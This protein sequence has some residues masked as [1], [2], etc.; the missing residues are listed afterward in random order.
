[1]TMF[2]KHF[3]ALALLFATLS[4]S[5]QTQIRVPLER[6]VRVVQSSGFPESVALGE[7]FDREAKAAYVFLVFRSPLTQ[8]ERFQLE[9]MGILLGP[10]LPPSV[11][12][13]E[14]PIDAAASLSRFSKYFSWLPLGDDRISKVLSQGIPEWSRV[15]NGRA[16]FNAMLLPGDQISTQ[17]V[18][19][20]GLGYSLRSIRRESDR[21][22]IEIEGPDQF[23]N[24][25]NLPFV[26]YLQESEEPGQPENFNAR[27][28]HRILS[29]QPRIES[30]YN[31]AG[32]VIGHGDDGAI[33]PHID[34]QGRMLADKS[35]ASS[36]THGDHVAGTILGG[37]NLD[38]RG[39]GM[40]PGADLVYYTYPDNLNDVD[41]DFSQYG[42]RI[43][44]SSY[45]NG[46][47][48]GYT[49]FSAQVDADINAN[50]GLQ[51]VF[52]A[53]NN[54]T[55]NCGYG[56][57]NLWG[58]ITGG[59]K[60]GKN[61]ITVANLNST[62][63]INSSS[64]RGPTAD[65]RIKP[66]VAAVGTNVY[67][68]VPPND[69]DSFTGTSMA[70][71]GT[72]GTTAV[73]Y[74]AYRETHSGND[75]AS[76]LLKG[77]LLNGADDLGNLG[78]D[79]IHGYGRINARAALED[80][81][82]NHFFTQSVDQSE[83][84]TFVLNV[85]AGTSKVKA[86]LI[87]TE[88]A[89]SPAALRDLVNNLD[90][91][92]SAAGSVYLPWVLDPS[93]NAVTLA[94]PAVQGVDSLNNIEQIT[95]DNPPALLS[96]SVSGS[97]VLQGPQE[98]Y[99]VY[100]FEGSEPLWESPAPSQALVPGQSEILRWWSPANATANIALDYSLDQGNTWVSIAQNLPS[101]ARWFNWNPP[102]S[103]TG[104]CRVRLTQGGF[105]TQT[106]D[107]SCLSVPSGLFVAQACPD[108]VELSWYGVLGATA[109]DVFALGQR[110]MDS[111]GT[112][113]STQGLN[114]I[115]I[116]GIAG[117]DE[118]WFAVRS[119]NAQ[120]P[121]QRSRAIFKP[122]G[123]LQCT[124]SRDLEA[125]SIL[126]PAPGLIPDCM[127]DSLNAGLIIKNS[128]SLS[129]H[130]Y[131][132]RFRLS[133]SL[134]FDS[135]LSSSD[136]LLPG[137]TDTVFI[138]LGFAL[139]AGSYLA[140]A[141]VLLSLDG[142]PS[143]DSLAHN[144][145]VSASSV[146]SGAFVSDFEN[147]TN[148]PSTTDCELTVCALD[149]FWTNTTNGSLDDIDWRTDNGGTP[150][151]GTGPS[152]DQ[153]PGTQAGKYLYLEASNGCSFQT[154]VL[155]SACLDLSAMTSPELSFWYHQ[156]GANQGELH[157]DLLSNG[158]WI[159]DALAPVLGNQGNVW[160]QAL[161]DLRPYMGSSLSIRIRGVTGS[162]FAS[163]LAIDHVSV[164]E[165]SS[166]PV[167]QFSASASAGC[168]GVPIQ[169]FE[170]CTHNP[171]QFQWVFSPATVAYVQGTSAQSANPVVVF[172][173]GG[174]YSAKL[175]AS[176]SLGSDSLAISQ[177]V[178][179]DG[180]RDLPQAES[181]SALNFPPA[182]YKQS[183]P[184]GSNTWVASNATGPNG[185]SSRCTRMSF[186]GYADFGQVD[187]LIS[188][189][190][191]VPNQ[192]SPALVFRRAHAQSM[193]GMSYDGL[194]IE[195]SRNCGLDFDASIFEKFGSDLATAAFSSQA[196]Q[197]QSS[198]WV[199]DTLDLS[200]FAGEELIFSFTAINGNGNHLYLDQIQWVDISQPAIG[201]AIILSDN[202]VCRGDTLQATAVP[203]APGAVSYSWRPGPGLIMPNTA[204]QGP[205][206]VIAQSVSNPV[207]GLEM[208]SEG[209]LVE[210]SAPIA[211]RGDVSAVFGS[212]L[213]ANL[214]EYA[215][216]ENFQGQPTDW[217]W[218]FGDGNS[219]L[220]AVQ[221][222]HAYANPGAYTVRLSAWNECGSDTAEVSIAV[223]GIGLDESNSSGV[224][225]YP[226]PLKN[227]LQA[228]NIEPAT[229]WTSLRLFDLNGR[230]LLE[231]S[232]EASQIEENRYRLL[233]PRLP[234]G[235][236]ILELE[237]RDRKIHHRLS[238]Q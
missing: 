73:L 131:A 24:L 223:S 60:V 94:N 101:T 27:S 195:L 227:G 51:H 209:G 174:V 30:G 182:G 205:V 74:Q 193:G 95:I 58:N 111:V 172:Q 199:W 16:R 137:Q 19:I 177:A 215:F 121:G 226:N 46:C 167:V 194:R 217:L 166:A 222:V 208:L 221:P 3:A 91:S 216:F 93:P 153:N 80:L 203:S 11:C 57:G 173:Q 154:A 7:N 229:E 225:V 198:D 200:P 143:N 218:E 168:V 88:P 188:P 45:S 214:Y 150:T 25:A 139:P 161:L 189:L 180:G 104:S 39:A 126:S 103:S 152:V 53:G 170:D 157:L 156:Y 55:Q 2:F 48:A 164:A 192:G 141:E 185:Q 134:A 183:N 4:S 202:D 59:H 77:Y 125:V 87:W 52:S 146:H 15:T 132:M 158:I 69:Y 86:M 212:S 36:G 99:I 9:R 83:Q 31:G 14:V 32:V 117:A 44:N 62:D 196:Y 128:G 213:T 149:S 230:L 66:D 5:A 18:R 84:R 191:R 1:M 47:N 98:F 110:Y 220:N 178:S 187:R 50:P 145:V 116:G 20:Q 151:S 35:G 29:V 119:R 169:F 142:N 114:S 159:E 127:S 61:T 115:K 65:G 235:M 96:L 97:A 79:F 112:A 78:P 206:D 224:S 26:L 118:H 100:R 120:G 236:Y 211:V 148:C 13:A 162:D 175:V 140:R 228:L 129:I 22:W 160:K 82:S 21:V 201:G 234:I 147:L 181:F 72:A 122:A 8:D 204:G 232:P 23:Q 184:D 49:G 165:V 12:Y 90:F 190:I 28:A 42:V 113:P 197:P 109:Y 207:L 34:Y 85:P 231:E 163:D 43:T 33:G 40:A 155:Q 63:G 171:N 179:V 37:G 54:G 138:P 64:S 38:P 176:N 6:G 68:T 210:L 56:A 41:L 233:L 67:S 219:A 81:E 124:V 17:F 135:V 70:C 237:S 75:P 92:I 10:A 107:L 123:L 108:T 133:G 71:P 105:S 130:S 136:T 89:A 144:F 238:I 186:Y 76:A 106:G 102:L